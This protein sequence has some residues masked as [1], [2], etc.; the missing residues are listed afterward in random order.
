LQL[1]VTDLTDV[2]LENLQDEENYDYDYVEEDNAS[3]NNMMGLRDVNNPMV[4]MAP[5]GHLFAVLCHCSWQEG[6]SVIFLIGI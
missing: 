3:T 6:V 1:F 4:S 5:A 2:L